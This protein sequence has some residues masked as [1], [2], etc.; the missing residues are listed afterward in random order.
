MKKQSR[1]V[2]VG[3]GLVIISLVTGVLFASELYDNKTFKSVNA[4]TQKTESY[5]I[6]TIAKEYT[7]ENLVV[8]NTK[9]EAEEKNEN[10]QPDFN[11]PAISVDK[12]EP[13]IPS[14]ET[15]KVEEEKQKAQ[16]IVDQVVFDGLTL[17]QLI[18][19][20][21]RNLNSTLSGMGHVYANYSLELGVDPYLAL[22]ISLHETGCKWTCSK[23]VRE[24]NN[25]GGQK[26][27]PSCNGGS[28]KKYDTIEE[29]IKG[30]ID[31]IKK[32]YYDYGLTTPE[33][34][35]KKYAADPEWSTKVNKYIDEIKAN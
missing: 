13:L 10:E 27:S 15:P 22:A 11:E 6:Q 16:E 29:G 35:N 7:P 23:L 14:E 25:V 19:K 12:V 34:M 9:T 3:I 4:I 20:L 30:Y 18:T 5:S 28:Y 1:E 32:N 17:E 21:D 24:C 33:T 31:N 26:G 2:T 8:F